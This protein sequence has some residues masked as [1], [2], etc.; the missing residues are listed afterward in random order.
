MIALYTA[1]LCSF[2]PNASIGDEFENGAGDSQAGQ[3]FYGLFDRSPFA[4]QGGSSA[5]ATFYT[6]EVDRVGDIPPLPTPPIARAGEDQSIRIA[7][8]TSTVVAL[9][10]S[11]SFDAGGDPLTY[12][13]DKAGQ[14]TIATGP[15]PTVQLGLG[16]HI[17]SLYVE[18]PSELGD[19]DDVVINGRITIPASELTWSFAR[20]SGPGGSSAAA[21]TRMRSNGP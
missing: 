12:R 10:G 14:G 20:S 19:T 18:D 3:G 2:L 1:L 15:T 7:S 8:G 17:I 6:G 16:T 11:M 4:G 9:N 21:V 5:S 13:W